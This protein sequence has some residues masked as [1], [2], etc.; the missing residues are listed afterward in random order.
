MTRAKNTPVKR[1]QDK[2]VLKEAEGYYGFG[3]KSPKKA[4]E[5]VIRSRVYAYRD[6]KQRKRDFRRI[7]IARLNA[8]LRDKYSLSYSRFIHLRNLIGIKLNRKRLSEMMINQPEHFDILVKK[9]K[10]YDKKT[11][12]QSG[13][14]VN[15]PSR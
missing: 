5:L 7:W 8:G 10:T 9:V 11:T 6:R 1:N 14:P 2:K 13:S 15:S 4:K 12:S 3:H